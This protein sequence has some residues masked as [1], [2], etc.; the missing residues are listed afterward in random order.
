VRVRAGG[1]EQIAGPTEY[2][3]AAVYGEPRVNVLKLN[4][5]LDKTKKTN[6]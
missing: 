2:G 4:I 3:F 6:P 5:A 1:K